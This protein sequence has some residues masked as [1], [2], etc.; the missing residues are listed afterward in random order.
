MP[1]SHRD[2]APDAARLHV[3]LN[4]TKGSSLSLN[5]RLLHA[6]QTFETTKSAAESASSA[7]VRCC[8][9]MIGPFSQILSPSWQMTR[10]LD[11]S[12]LSTARFEYGSPKM[13]TALT[14]DMTLAPRLVAASCTTI[15]PCEYPLSTILVLGHLAATSWIAC[16]LFIPR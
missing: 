7:Y 8:S 2:I 1:S 12:M 10:T 14:L 15:P 6:H 13:T 11:A 4:T 3:M 5:Q 9:R 16:A